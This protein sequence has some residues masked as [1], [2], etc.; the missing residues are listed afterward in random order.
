MGHSR[1][2][3]WPGWDIQFFFT[4]YKAKNGKLK[5]VKEENNFFAN[6]TWVGR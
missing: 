5:V 4:T 2:V 6:G 1:L 3:G